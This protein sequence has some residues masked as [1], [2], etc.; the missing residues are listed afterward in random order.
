[1]PNRISFSRVFICFTLFFACALNGCKEPELKVLRYGDPFANLE[2]NTEDQSF[3]LQSIEDELILVDFWASWCKP[4]RKVNPELEAI[5]RKYK[6][7]SYRGG[8]NGFRIVSFSFDDKLE[9]WQSAIAKDGMTWPDQYCEG[10]SMPDSNVPMR[11][12]FLQIPTSFLL[13]SDF[14]VIG[15]NLSSKGLEY[16]LKLRLLNEN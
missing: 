5:Y 12:G 3:D 16:E 1:M 4:C 8:K 13:D 15:K 6:S 14:K 2:I 7:E 10:K 11:Y 9:R